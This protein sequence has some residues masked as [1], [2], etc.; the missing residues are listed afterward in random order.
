MPRPANN[1][2]TDAEWAQ[3]RFPEQTQQQ[4]YKSLRTRA[5][6]VH[7]WVLYRLGRYEQAEA[8]LRQAVAL[9]RTEKNLGHLAETL[10]KLGRTS[11]AERLAF[12]AKNEYAAA[13]KRQFKNEP[14][15]DFELVAIDGRR[16]KLSDLKG[17]VVVLDFWATWCGPCVK[18]VPTLV[19]LY[20]KYRARGLEIL[21]I[22]V[23]EQAD[24]YK[25][26]PFAKEYQIAYPVL[27]DAGAKELYNVKSFPTTIFI[28]RA[29]QVRYRDT[30]F[31]TETPRMWDTLVE[32]ILQTK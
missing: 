23:D 21:S 5:L 31:S 8:K 15:K 30:G 12:E 29:G 27:L 22:T 17:K 26:A 10:S 6:D 18:S 2:D 19:Q 32:Q 16:V 14:A 28:D 24:L 11:E 20:E 3:D 7:G 13:L 25:I 4:F 1:G 9:A